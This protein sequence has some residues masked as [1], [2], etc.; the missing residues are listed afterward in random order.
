MEKSIGYSQR[1]CKERSERSR[2]VF[3]L[4]KTKKANRIATLI[5]A[6]I[7]SRE[8]FLTLMLR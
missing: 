4:F 2:R 1:A 3:V 6:Q 5:F 7:P 8:S